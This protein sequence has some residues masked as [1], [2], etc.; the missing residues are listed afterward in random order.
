MDASH[1]YHARAISSDSRCH[2][3][4]VSVGLGWINSDL[5]CSRWWY[6]LVSGGIDGATVDKGR[7]TPY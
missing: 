1:G 6:L 5:R 2:A 3:V 4:V 7:I